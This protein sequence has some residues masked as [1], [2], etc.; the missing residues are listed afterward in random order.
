MQ[1]AHAEDPQNCATC[2]GPIDGT[3]GSC[4]GLQECLS[5]FDD[6]PE[7]FINPWEFDEPADLVRRHCATVID[8][9]NL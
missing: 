5:S 2:I 6:R 9:E 3:L 8:I 7:H 1:A 4:A